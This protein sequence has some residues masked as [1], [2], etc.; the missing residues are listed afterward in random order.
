MRAINEILRNVLGEGRLGG[1]IVLALA[2]IYIPGFLITSVHLGQFGIARLELLH[3]RAIAAGVWFLFIALVAGL[4]AFLPFALVFTGLDFISRISKRGKCLYSLLKKRSLFS[5]DVRLQADLKDDK[6]TDTFRQEFQSHG[7]SL[8][9]DPKIETIETDRRWRIADDKRSQAYIVIKDGK[10][11]HIYDERLL[12]RLKKWGRSILE[13]IVFLGLGGIFYAL[14]Y[15]SEPLASRLIAH[16]IGWFE[17]GRNVALLT[18]Y[19]RECLSPLA[20]LQGVVVFMALLLFHYKDRV[21]PAMQKAFVALTLIAFVV[22][23]AYCLFWCA[24][25]LYGHLSVSLGGGK[26]VPVQIVATGNV[27]PELEK[28]GIPLR[29]KVVN[30]DD[31]GRTDTVYLVDQTVSEGATRTYFVLPCAPIYGC[32]T[33]EFDSTL[34]KGVVYRPPKPMLVASDI[35]SPLKGTPP[36]PIALRWPLTS[37]TTPVPGGGVVAILPMASPL[38][39]ISPVPTAPIV[40]QTPIPTVLH[41]AMP[42][43]T[44]VATHTTTPTYTP[45][46]TTTPTRTPTTTPTRTPTATPTTPPPTPRP[47]EPTHTPAPIPT[48]T[49]TRTFTA[50]PTQT[51][52]ATPRPTSTQTPTVTPT[53]PV[54]PTATFTPSPT[55]LPPTLTPT[56]T[57]T[58]TF[59][60]T[61]SHTPTL[62]PTP[63]VPSKP[64]V[65]MV[66]VTDPLCVSGQVVVQITLVALGGQE[67]YEYSPAQNFQ[68]SYPPGQAV[69]VPVEV[70]SADGQVWNAEIQLPAVS[71]D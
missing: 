8:S 43:H 69:A 2:S 41:T 21:Y 23:L 67:P 5:V 20:R 40:D 26:P 39:G 27:L 25:R 24:S 19:L 37:T 16:L 30:E 57:H 9:D 47:G 58:P 66:Y 64:L 6:L 42:T 48:S 54:A 11:L 60:P 31:W 62:T 7:I 55:A 44:P 52:T 18:Q 38:P 46:P 63:S 14:F 15:A 59:T 70:R 17:A 49:P 34:V 65:V 68:Y 4:F 33:I 28:L 36:V 22:S 1:I 12:L 13:V 10:A 56:F 45:T 71:C 61:P 32:Q 29:G 51:P 35:M 53:S 50:T 3:P